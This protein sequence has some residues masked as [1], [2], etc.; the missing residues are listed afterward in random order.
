MG[1]LRWIVQTRQRGTIGPSGEEGGATIPDNPNW[2]RHRNACIH[3]REHWPVDELDEDGLQ[4][5]YVAICLQNTPP[6][7]LD[8]Q[9]KCMQP[10][11]VCWRITEALIREKGA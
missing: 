8:E 7:T 11:K 5:L 1:P 6:M 2:R 9:H 10:R 3:Y 4:V